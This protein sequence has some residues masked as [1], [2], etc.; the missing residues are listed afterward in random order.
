MQTNDIFFRRRLPSISTSTPNSVVLHWIQKG[1]PRINPY[2]YPSAL[3]TS[4]PAHF[5][6]YL[7]ISYS[8]SV[9]KGDTIIH[10]LIIFAVKELRGIILIFHCTFDSNTIVGKVEKTEVQIFATSF[11]P[12]NTAL[13]GLTLN[14]NMH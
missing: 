2:T 13:T 3:D 5:V 1:F 9:R 7:R 12:I 10:Y 14:Y 8:H 6:I 4:H 11:G